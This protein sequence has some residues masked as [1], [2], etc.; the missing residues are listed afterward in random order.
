MSI[1]FKEILTPY[2]KDR[3]AK[4]YIQWLT[5]NERMP[6]QEH[7]QA[8]PDAASYADQ[9]I[10]ATE[11]LRELTKSLMG[12]PDNLDKVLLASQIEKMLIGI[13]I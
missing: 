9:L 8:H 7:N 13:K 12:N 3:R 10:H 5:D 11:L 4:D 1:V 6:K 2:E